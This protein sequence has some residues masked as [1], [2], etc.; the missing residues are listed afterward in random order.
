MEDFMVSLLSTA[1]DVRGARL[2]TPVLRSSLA[3]A[4]GGSPREA[5]GSA[6]VANGCGTISRGE[7]PPPRRNLRLLRRADSACAFIESH[8]G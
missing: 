1:A 3:K 5:V 7:T 4:G 2:T 6:V 8:T